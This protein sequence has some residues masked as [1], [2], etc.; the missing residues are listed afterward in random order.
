MARKGKYI[1][2]ESRLRVAWN[3]RVGINIGIK[4]GGSTNWHEKY[5]WTDLNILKLDFDGGCKTL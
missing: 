1:E 4:K 3:Q 2:T 5:F